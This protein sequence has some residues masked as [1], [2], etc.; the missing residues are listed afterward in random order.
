MS[1]SKIARKVNKNATSVLATLTLLS[2]AKLLH[3]IIAAM[4]VTYLNYPNGSTVVGGFMM[5]TS[6]SDTLGKS[7]FHYL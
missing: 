5:E 1:T 6:D 3:T 4:S 7:T 2:Y